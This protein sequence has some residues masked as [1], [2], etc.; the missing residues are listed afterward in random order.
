LK[1]LNHYAQGEDYVVEPIYE[2]ESQFNVK[3]IFSPGKPLKLEYHYAIKG[4]RDFV[5]IC[6][7]YPENQITGMRW[8][9]RGPYRVWK[10][11]LAGQQFG[12]WHKNYNNA[13]TG[14]SWEYP[15]FK[16]YH[17]EVYW[18][19]I[20]NKQ[21]AFTVYSEQRNTFF[22]MLKPAKANGAKNDYTSPSFPEGNIGF[23]HAISPIGTKFQTADKM[24]PQSQKNM[25]LNYTPISG[26]LWFDFD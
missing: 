7:N 10:N 20:E 19:T 13:I 3:W 23:L 12:V 26:S 18:V 17:S 8:E 24:G 16:G 22:Q 6:F 1:R 14:E 21:A 4:E 5:G 25:Q 11:R 9:G 2:G 15:E